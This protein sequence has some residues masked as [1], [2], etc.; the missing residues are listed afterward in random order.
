M[1][2]L[3]E[4]VGERLLRH[5]RG[6]LAERHLDHHD[7]R[8][9]DQLTEQCGLLPPEGHDLLGR[10]ACDFPP[11]AF[12]R[13]DRVGREGHR[14][15]GGF[16]PDRRRHARREQ[17]RSDGDAPEASGTAN[18]AACR[19]RFHGAPLRM[20]TT[21]CSAFRL[22]LPT[23]KVGCGAQA[24]AP[25]VRRPSRQRAS[26]PHAAATHGV[27]KAIGRPGSSPRGGA[28]RRRARRASGQ[29]P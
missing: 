9:P 24:L 7:V 18:G 11:V 2:P 3:K 8:R 21:P 29:L 23:G 5:R 17:D 14:A 13:R 15:L 12:R 6:F 16:L 19:G 20:R 22:A 28:S 10:V 1:L 25:A 27:N 26:E 4:A